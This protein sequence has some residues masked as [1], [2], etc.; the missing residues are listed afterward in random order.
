MI[1]FCC[2]LISMFVLTT[3]SVAGG[4]A[5]TISGEDTERALSRLDKEIAI[6]QV[7]MDSRRSLIDSLKRLTAEGMHTRAWLDHILQ[8]GDL[9]APF[10][11]DSALVYFERGLARALELREDSFMTVFR[12]RHAVYLPLAGLNGEALDEFSLI[13]RDSLTA[14]GGAT[15]ASFYDSERQLHSYL[16]AAYRKYEPLKRLHEQHVIEAQR[17]LLQTLDS[18]TV[19]YTYALG[20]YF[21]N[22][23]DLSKAQVL[24]DEIVQTVDESRN[25]FARAAHHLSSIAQARG[26]N[27]AY[28]YYLALSAIGDVKSATLEVSSLQELGRELFNHGQKE[29]AYL[30]LSTAL[31]NAVSCH[32][33]SRM[34]ESA[35]ALPTISAA[36]R[37]E[38]SHQQKILYMVISLMAVLLL[39][40]GAAMIYLRRDM[41][42]LSRLQ[43]RLEKA[44]HV[45]EF[46]ISQFLNL[47]S[48]YMDK[49]NEFCKIAN[50]KISTGN[51]DDLYK[52][53][54]SGKFVDEQ[55]REFYEVFDNAFLHL[56]P[57]FVTEVDALLKDDCKLQ[58]LPD[59]TLNTDLRI[60]ALMR[61]GIDDCRHIARVLNYSVNTIYAYRN[62]LKNRALRRDTFE[63]EV[64]EIGK[65]K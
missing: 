28:I 9:Y 20:E 32:A 2:F 6:R 23:G 11:N 8:L 47:S 53:T 48:I 4:R 24:L 45:K 26:D 3:A 58:L 14:R 41:K 63:A 46:Y 57:T 18:T 31:E 13:N 36:H 29:R 64:L 50:R 55:S 65:V 51:V 15:P 16:V 38:I 59:E 54:K 33:A 12:M 62:K 19:N 49:L 22:T 44:N 30:Y 61:L 43:R 39:L 27:E 21:F 10:N 56:Y 7:Y 5:V 60:L 17:A 34:M 25:M 37:S 35:E 42:R 1:R 52:L 40:L